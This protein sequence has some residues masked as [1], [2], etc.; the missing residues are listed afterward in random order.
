MPAV[1]SPIVCA[2]WHLRYRCT[3][4]EV[5]LA[6]VMSGSRTVIPFAMTDDE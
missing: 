4:L 3:A 5:A 1:V 6:I 2:R